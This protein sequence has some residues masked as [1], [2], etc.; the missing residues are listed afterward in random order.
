M[1]I[2][3]SGLWLLFGKHLDIIL[4]AFGHHFPAIWTLREP[5]GTRGGA[6]VDFGWIWGAI[7]DPLGAAF[8]FLGGTGGIF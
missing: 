6:K 8:G 5:C 4:D 2:M 7:W 3:F 1:F